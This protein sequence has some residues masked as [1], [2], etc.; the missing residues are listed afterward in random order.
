MCASLLPGAACCGCLG[1]SRP[2]LPPPPARHT[3]YSCSC[4]LNCPPCCSNSGSEWSA[5]E[6][7]QRTCSSGGER[8]R[9]WQHQLSGARRMQLPTYLT[10]SPLTSTHPRFLFDV[11]RYFYAYV[12][13]SSYYYSSWS[14]CYMQ[15][16]GSSGCGGREAPARVQADLRGACCAAAL[17]CIGTSLFCRVGMVC[18]RVS[19]T[20]GLIHPA[21]NRHPPARP[22][23]PLLPS[24]AATSATTAGPQAAWGCSSLCGYSS[25]S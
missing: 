9:R 14:T 5:G 7:R 25:C 15:A 22:A 23:S 2:T 19:H 10:Q 17:L 16:P 18:S 3:L 1:G 4:C 24:P 11:N 8:G 6:G 13:G 20:A 12:S 21:P